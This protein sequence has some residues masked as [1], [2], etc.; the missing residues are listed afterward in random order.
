[1]I[2]NFEK[3]LDLVLQSEGGFSINPFDNGNKLPDGR[4]GC[5]NK[6]ITQNSWEEFVGHKVSHNDMRN[7]TQEQIAKFYKAKFWKLAKCD[8]L[9]SGVDY[10]VFDFS[11]NAGVGRAVKTLQQSIGV[12]AD[13]LIGAIT[14]AELAK[15][16][17]T[18]L[19]SKFSE[20]KIEFY[21]DL[22]ARKPDQ[23]VFLKGWLNR[24]SHAKKN[25]DYLVS[26]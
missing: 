10:V 15:C 13:G 2:S 18:N 4:Q 9:P 23:Q 20:K 1:M 21:Q 6:G 8:E 3:A 12:S 5:T 22:V 24:V 25:A 14:L 19:I 11:V 7:L 26:H 17:T 16:N